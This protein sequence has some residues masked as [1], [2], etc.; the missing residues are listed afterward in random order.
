MTNFFSTMD[1][2]TIKS[3]MQAQGMNLTDDQINLMKNKD[4]IKT[5]HKQMKDNPDQFKDKMNYLNAMKGN[6]NFAGNNSNPEANNTAASKN[7]SNS[8]EVERKPSES[9]SNDSSSKTQGFPDLSKLPK[10]MDMNS[11]MEFMSKNPE[12]LK[13]ISPQMAQM[14]GGSGNNSDGSNKGGMPPQLETIFWLLGLPQRIKKFFTSTKG[15]IIT[16][17]FGYLVYSYFWG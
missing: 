16:I 8:E 2:N 7:T 1:N 14:F 11:M 5:A 15:I 13:M 9:K 10:N 3:M 4:L 17:S 12:L 6:Q